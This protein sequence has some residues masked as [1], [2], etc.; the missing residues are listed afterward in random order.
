LS[1]FPPACPVWYAWLL[2]LLTDIPVTLY[3]E[4]YSSIVF[5]PQ[6]FFD[7]AQDGDLLNRRWFQVDP[8]SGELGVET[9]GV[10]L[11]T[12]SIELSEPAAGVL[13]QGEL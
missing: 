6:N 5:A 8:E 4:A 1:L 2:T 11:P 7:R 3:T 13:P 10:E 12:C 9:Y